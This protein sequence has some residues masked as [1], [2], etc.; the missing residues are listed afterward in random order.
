MYYMEHQSKSA[1]QD[2]IQLGRA[3]DILEYLAEA[4]APRGLTEL[5]E[6][7][8]GPKATVHRLLM[9]L[10]QRGYVTQDTHTARY[11]AGVRCFELGSNWAAN[12]DLRRVA[13]PHLA[14]L[15]E[16]TLETVHLAIYD[17][18][19]S[20]YVEKLDCRHPVVAVSR[21]G[22][23]C[24]ATCVAT[25]RALLAFQDQAEI[26]EVLSRPLPAYTENSATDPGELRALLAQVRRDGYAA[27]HA[28]YRPGVGGLAAPIRDYRGQV[29]ASVGVCLPEQRF[30]PDQFPVLL[31]ATVSAAVAISAALGGPR[32]L[33]T[34]GLADAAAE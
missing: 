11:G 3:L 9:T 28:S 7:V 23:R 15:N 1:G 19:D 4:P 13:A 18:G 34:T 5:S 21:V 10:Q 25:G 32:E 29:I 14:E 33:V 2:S 6:H 16:S 30:G 27:N 22:R 24:P 17:H 31:S 8:G 12:L 20:V 26:D